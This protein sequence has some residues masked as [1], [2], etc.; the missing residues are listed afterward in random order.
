MS[1]SAPT[2]DINATFRGGGRS[3]EWLDEINKACIVMLAE[4]GIVP[5]DVAK[6][7]ARGIAQVI[8]NEK[9]GEKRTSAD[10]LDYEP[11]LIAVAGQEASR[12]H[13]GRSRQDLAST[14][15]RM[16]LRDGLL[17]TIGALIADREKLLKRAEEHIDTIIPAYTHGVQAQPTTFAH[18]LL[19]FESALARATERLQQAY[20]RVNK[21]PLGTAAL[22]TS[23]F[24]LDRHRLA[25]L[26]GF[27]GLVENAYDANHLAPIDS[28]LDVANA[29]AMTAVQTGMF[30]QDLHTQYAEPTPWFMLADGKL[31]GTSSIMPQKR[32]PAALEQ[33]RAQSSILLSEMQTM[34]FVAHNNRTGMFDYRMYDPVPYARALTVF[35]L[36][37]SVVDA[38]VVNKAR[39]LEEVNADYSTTTEIADALLQ[40]AEVPFRTGHHFASKLTDFGRGK[41]LKIHEI[42]YSEAQRIYEEQAKDKLPL[43]EQEFREVI[44]AETMVFGRKG[45]GGPQTIETKRAM[46]ETTAQ[47]KTNKDWLDGQHNQ[48]NKTK[49]TA[50]KMFRELL[51]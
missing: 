41:G 12:L 4:T 38:V 40:K 36:F 1:D 5:K 8:E 47:T 7:I 22:A 25:E 26:L 35:K 30:A 33:L 21:C 29:Y 2:L 43:T 32:N 50:N 23:S 24:P 46:T 11:R 18:Y 6:R 16:N 28:A 19:A 37:G 34:T 49:K 31:T 20:T 10:Y 13:T 45:L 15:A 44:S 9:N 51:Q 27:E 48:T 3:I 39:A 17:H 42:A 14:I